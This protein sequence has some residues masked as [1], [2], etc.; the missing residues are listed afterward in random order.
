MIETRLHAPGRPGETLDP[1][2]HDH[3]LKDRAPQDRALRQP[4]MQ[5]ARRVHGPGMAVSI[6]FVG[7]RSS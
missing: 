6:L 4:D 3:A 1:S 7:R 5:R 2:L